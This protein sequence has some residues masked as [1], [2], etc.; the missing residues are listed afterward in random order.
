MGTGGVSLSDGFIVSKAPALLLSRLR[1]KSFRRRATTQLRCNCLP[2]HPYLVGSLPARGGVVDGDAKS[3]LAPTTAKPFLLSCLRCRGGEVLTVSRL[4]TRGTLSGGALIHLVMA[5]GCHGFGRVVEA[6]R[7]R[8]AG[9]AFQNRTKLCSRVVLGLVY[10]GDAAAGGRVTR[11]TS[12][13]HIFL[14]RCRKRLVLPLA[15]T[16]AVA[17]AGESVR[18]AHPLRPNVVNDAPPGIRCRRLRHGDGQRGRCRV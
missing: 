9:R 6:C 16:M 15:A 17:V 1:R 4:V 13:S 8:L 3:D 10:R 7:L 12:R 2:L 18:E 11:P 14:Q 5:D